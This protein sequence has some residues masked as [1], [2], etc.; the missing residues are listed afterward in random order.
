A[1]TYR[2]YGGT[3]IQAADALET[4]HFGANAVAYRPQMLLAF[5]NL[6]LA[7]TKFGKVPYV[8]AVIGDATGDDVNY[9]EAFQRLAYSP[10]VGY[11]SA[12]FET[13]GITDGLVSGGLI[14]AQDTEFLR[15]IQQFGRFYPS[16]DILQTDKLRIVDRATVTADITLN[17]TR[18]M[19]KVVITRQEPNSVAAI[20]ELS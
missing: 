20:L 19:D 16:W 15:A 2:F 13:T 4:L 8:A 10:W 7:N 1:F 17:K 14:F 3:L 9:G 11:T 18:L 12:Q 6:P 5:E